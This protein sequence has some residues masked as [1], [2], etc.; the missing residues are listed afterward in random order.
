MKYLFLFLLMACKIA[1]GQSKDTAKVVAFMQNKTTKS[2]H[3]ILI[4][5][6][7]DSWYY[8]Q[9][10]KFIKLDLKKEEIIDSIPYKNPN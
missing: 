1:Y 10:S 8:K 4:Y 3:Y 2:K 7:K 5:K 9:E 6:I